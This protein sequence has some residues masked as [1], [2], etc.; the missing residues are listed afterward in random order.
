MLDQELTI[1][2]ALSVQLLATI[3]SQPLQSIAPVYNEFLDVRVSWRRLSEPFDEPIFPDGVPDARR[4]P[5]ARWAGHVRRRSTS[6]I[7]GPTRPVLRDVSFTLEPARSPRS[8]DTPAPASRASPSCWC[9]PTTP[10]PDPSTSAAPTCATSASTTSARS[11]AS[12]RRIRSCSRAPW[13][14]TSATR[15]PMPPTTRSKRRSAPS[16]RGHCCPCSRAIRARRRGGG[17]QPHRCAT[18]A[19]GARTGLDRQAR[20]P[21]ARRGD[22]TARLGRRGHDHRRDP[23]LGLHD[24][25]DH[26]SRVRGGAS[27][28]HR[29]PG[30][31]PGRRRRARGRSR[32]A[33]AARTTGSG[34]SRKT[35]SP[36]RRT[37]SSPAAVPYR[38]VGF[39]DALQALGRLDPLLD[40]VEDHVAAPG[41]PAF[42]RPTIWPTGKPSARGSATA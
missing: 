9:A 30:G 24:A 42:M 29:R 27:R 16:A 38:S 19:R 31:R 13:R 25:D 23:P 20:P 12:S 6:R 18:P 11:S 10:T 21:P 17:P 28:L 22:V 35:S 40:H 15:S 36:R 3:A 2:A 39:G 41:A 33:P 26:P 4:L 8:S 34:A 1:G 37:R 7:P 5:T 32:R 14:R